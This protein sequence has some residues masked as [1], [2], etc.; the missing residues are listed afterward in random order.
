VTF[1]V[2]RPLSRL[3]VVAALVAVLGLAGCGRKGPLDPPPGA[4]VESPPARQTGLANGMRSPRAAQP[5]KQAATQAGQATSAGFDEDG[6]P[7][8]PKG[9]Q[10]RFFLDWLL[11]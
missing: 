8:A 5:D 1:C 7:I 3:A 6:Q 11:E 4:A 9:Q 2:I 10:R